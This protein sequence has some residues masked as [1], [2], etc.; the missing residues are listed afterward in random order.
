MWKFTP[1]AATPPPCSLRKKV[2]FG[3]RSRVAKPVASLSVSSLNFG[4]IDTKPSLLMTTDQFSLSASRPWTPKNSALPP[5]K[6]GSLCGT[7]WYMNNGLI[8]V[9]ARGSSKKNGLLTGEIRQS[10]AWSLWNGRRLQ[11][12]L[13]PALKPKNSP[14]RSPNVLLSGWSMATPGLYGSPP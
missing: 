6:S 11:E 1:A 4:W 14:Q 10:K 8:S 3:P 13:A 12:L 5:L 2:H 7:D 9:S